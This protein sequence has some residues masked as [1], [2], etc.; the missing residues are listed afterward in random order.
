MLTP[1]DREDLTKRLD[2]LLDEVADFHLY[3]SV[4]WEDYKNR[5]KRR[6]VERWIENIINASIDIAKVLLS[7]K[8]LE[9]PQ[10][11]R[12]ILRDISLTNLF[13]EE[14][15]LKISEWASIRNKLAHEYI[16]IRWDAIK[17][18]VKESQPSLIEFTNIIKKY[19]T[20]SLSDSIER[21]I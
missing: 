1:A 3:Q 8:G 14:L 15:G 4:T 20:E 16:D 5:R 18:F 2:F 10:T 7:V 9:I 12:E 19:L 21:E 6:E 17:K 13:R 11:Y